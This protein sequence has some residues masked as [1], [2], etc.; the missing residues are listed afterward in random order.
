MKAPVAAG[1]YRRLAQVGLAAVMSFLAGSRRMSGGSTPGAAGVAVMPRETEVGYDTV[2][3]L[4]ITVLGQIPSVG[5]SVSTRAFSLKS[6][7]WTDGASTRYSSPPPLQMRLMRNERDRMF[8]LWTLDLLA[9][10]LPALP[11]SAIRCLAILILWSVRR[12][13]HQLGDRCEAMQRKIRRLT[14]QSN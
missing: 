1:M 10:S 2:G 11:N 9:R 12:E 6:R 4:V 3:G 13:L 5:Q 7:T 14:D 8:H